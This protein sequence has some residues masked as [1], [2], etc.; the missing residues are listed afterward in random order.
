MSAPQTPNAPPMVFADPTPLGLLGLAIGCAA[1]VP[2]AF[3][4]LPEPA[5]IPAMLHTA[6]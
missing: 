6:A 4:L 5:K 3:G 2:I 1:L